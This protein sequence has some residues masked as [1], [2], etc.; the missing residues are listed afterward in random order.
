MVSNQFEIVGVRIAL[1]AP[2]ENIRAEQVVG[3][4]ESVVDAHC[5]KVLV[6]DLLANKFE[7]PGIS[8]CP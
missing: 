4:R 3:L 1:I 6:G 8:R 2:V 7:R 5:G